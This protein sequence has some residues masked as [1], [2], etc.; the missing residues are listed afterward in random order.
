MAVLLQNIWRIGVM[1]LLLLCSAFFSGSETA[2]FNLSTRQMR[3]LRESQHRSQ[4]LVAYLLERPGRLLNSLLFGNMT[5]NVLYFSLSSVF[6]MAVGEKAGIT[7]AGLTALASFALLV[8]FGEILPKS[9][10]YAGS[11][12]MSMVAAGPAYLWLKAFGPLQFVFR[13][14]VLEPTLRI[15]LGPTRT[16]HSLTIGEFRSLIETTRSQ[17]LITSDEN[18]LLTEV[19]ELGFLKVRHVMRPRVDIVGCSVAESAEAVRELLLANA[20]TKL[21]VYSGDI[22]NILGMVHFRRLLLE[23]PLQHAWPFAQVRITWC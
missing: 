6:T 10:A 13:A 21:P 9:L 18:M 4:K 7:A 20:L 17:G 23:P 15:L 11:R 12:S 22:D 8:L 16:P 2:F 19:I 14:F 3:L 5:V 1:L